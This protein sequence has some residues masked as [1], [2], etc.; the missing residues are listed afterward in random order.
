M[1]AYADRAGAT[2]ENALYGT[3]EEIREMIEALLDNGV[4]YVLLAVAG[5][6]DQLRHFAREFMPAFV[7]EPTARA[8]E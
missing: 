6:V 3:P 5:G 2:E 1:L 4:A 8:A 7:Q